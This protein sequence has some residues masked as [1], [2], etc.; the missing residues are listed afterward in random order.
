MASL[1]PIVAT[2]EAVRK[3][4]TCISGT[5]SR[6][7][8]CFI[9][10][11]L[12]VESYPGVPLITAHQDRDLFHGDDLITVGRKAEVVA[13]R[14][15]HVTRRAGRETTKVAYFVWRGAFG[16]GSPLSVR[17]RLPEGAIRGRASCQATLLPA[18]WPAAS[19]CRDGVLPRSPWS[20]SGAGAAVG[21]WCR[22][23]CWLN[24]AGRP[25]LIQP[26]T[27]WPTASKALAGFYRRPNPGTAGPA[28]GSQLAGHVVV[29]GRW[30]GLGLA[31]RQLGRPARCRPPGAHGVIS[32][33]TETG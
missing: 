9:W 25:T 21:R 26:Q 1:A 10:R 17:N 4:G 11:G 5:G 32:Y 33:R 8:S 6:E 15:K 24:R 30:R 28:A 31:G 29:C 3:H 2:A 23:P 12:P 7:L 22:P 13:Q 27:E 14:P 19:G 20:I 18:P 16:P